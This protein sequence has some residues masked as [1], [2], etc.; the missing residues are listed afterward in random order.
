M[1]H[2]ARAISRLWSALRWGGGQLDNGAV[3]GLD[4]EVTGGLESEAD[5]VSELRTA[6]VLGGA[7]G[8]TGGHEWSEPLAKHVEGPGNGER[9]RVVMVLQPAP[10]AH[11]QITE[12]EL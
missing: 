11:T 5:V 4:K 8:I 12:V 3:S 9:Q 2:R 7:C 10:A 6:M 1:E